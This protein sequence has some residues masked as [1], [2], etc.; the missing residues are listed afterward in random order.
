MQSFYDIE[1]IFFPLAIYTYIFLF[2][3]NQGYIIEGRN[4]IITNR[5]YCVTKKKY[6]ILNESY[7]LNK[8]SAIKK[9]WN[10]A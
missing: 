3:S 9:V 2:M 4:K 10:K 6:V 7:V 8:N 1:I 5:G